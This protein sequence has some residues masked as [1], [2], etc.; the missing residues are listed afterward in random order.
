MPIALR[1]LCSVVV[2]FKKKKMFKIYQ[3]FVCFFFQLET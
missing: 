1:I 2:W 3:I